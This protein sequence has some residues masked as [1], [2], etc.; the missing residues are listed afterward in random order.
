MAQFHFKRKRVAVVLTIAITALVWTIHLVSMV[1]S[2]DVALSV[3][4]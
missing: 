3:F 4:V 2:M 1:L